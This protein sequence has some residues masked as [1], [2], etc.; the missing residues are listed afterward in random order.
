MLRSQ[1]DTCRTRGVNIEIPEYFQTWIN[2]KQVFSHVMGNATKGM[3]GMLH[4][5]GMELEGRHHS[6][7]DDCRN[8]A[9]I[10]IRL[11]EI[12]R[13]KATEKEHSQI[14]QVQFY[15]IVMEAYVPVEPDDDVLVM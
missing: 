9:A 1:I 6:G 11:N 13:K 7:I 10:A 5:L 8:I 12:A 14:H 4:Q 2:I 3:S 15:L